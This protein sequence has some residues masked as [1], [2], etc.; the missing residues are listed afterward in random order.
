MNVKLDMA[1]YHKDIEC[2]IVRR[3]KDGR[4]G[5]LKL[6]RDGVELPTRRNIWIDFLW[7]N[8]A[9]TKYEVAKIK[10]INGKAYDVI[11]CDDK[12]IIHYNGELKRQR[13][14]W[15]AQKLGQ[16]VP[17]DTLES[18]EYCRQQQEYY[19]AHPIESIH[20][21]D[22]HPSWFDNK[23]ASKFSNK[24]LYDAYYYVKDEMQYGS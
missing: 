5:L 24:E 22:Q 18:E 2:R 9:D 6:Y 20:I 4:S 23:P 16:P 7:I 19:E 21:S 17:E 15:V 11:I 13:Q 1:K 3:S 14:T 12:G 8:N 10:E